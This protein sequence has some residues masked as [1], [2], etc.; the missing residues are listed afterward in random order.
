VGIGP[1]REV[2]RALN[3]PT[4][5]YV[6]ASPTTAERAV[7]VDMSREAAQGNSSRAPCDRVLS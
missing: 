2:Y 3:L 1:R 7:S 5:A 4:A 6:E